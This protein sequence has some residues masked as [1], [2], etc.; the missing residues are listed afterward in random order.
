MSALLLVWTGN[1]IQLFHL[2][3]PCIREIAQR[4]A[5]G[6]SRAPCLNPVPRGNP[7]WFGCCHKVKVVRLDSLNHC[8]QR[9]LAKGK[10]AVH[11]VGLTCPHPS[12]GSCSREVRERGDGTGCAEPVSHKEDSGFYPKGGESPGGLWA[13][14]GQSSCNF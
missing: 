13:E 7:G 3:H 14:E 4:A 10:R 5:M 6:Q 8:P 9:A 2:G 1:L 12:R 11:H